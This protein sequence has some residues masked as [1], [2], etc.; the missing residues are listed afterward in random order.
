MECPHTKVISIIQ[1]ALHIEQ[2]VSGSHRTTSE[3]REG[4][5][6]CCEQGGFIIYCQQVIAFSLDDLIIQMFN[7][8]A[9]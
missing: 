5:E 2:K 4:V 6:P 8:L 7:H 3:F 1:N 9:R